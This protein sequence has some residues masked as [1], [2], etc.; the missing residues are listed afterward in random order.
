MVYKALRRPRIL[1]IVHLSFH[2]RV[3]LEVW[4]HSG[5]ICTCIKERHLRHL[6]LRLKIEILLSARAHDPVR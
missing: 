3:L 5:T 4:R 2:A 6:I 1:I